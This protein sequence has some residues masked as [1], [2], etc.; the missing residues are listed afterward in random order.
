MFI[1]F[2]SVSNSMGTSQKLEK[3]QYYFRIFLNINL[4][5]GRNKERLRSSQ[6]PCFT[7][8]HLEKQEKKLFCVAT[9][10]NNKLSFLILSWYQEELQLYIEKR[11][12]RAQVGSIVCFEQTVVWRCDVL[13]WASYFCFRRK[14]SFHHERFV[15]VQV[16]G[17]L[18]VPGCPT[19]LDLK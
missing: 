19:S 4:I 18:L 16:G 3:H 10:G 11:P 13:L 2:L 5:K 8:Y 6:G 17:R 7:I 14:F 9:L 15:S 1:S 12:N